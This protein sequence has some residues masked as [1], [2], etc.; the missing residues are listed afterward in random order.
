MMSFYNQRNYFKTIAVGLGVVLLSSCSAVRSTHT[1]AVRSTHPVNDS[2]QFKKL[3]GQDNFVTVDLPHTFNAYDADDGGGYYVGPTQYTKTF[4]SPCSEDQLLYI[5]F[6][7]SALRTDVSVN[8]SKIGRHDGGY[9]Q[10]RFHI[11]QDALKQQNQL[12]VD[13][14]NSNFEQIA[15]LAGDFSVFGGIYR[16]V[17]FICA[18]AL[19]FDLDDYGSDGI[20]IKSVIENAEQAKV[21]IK[22][23]VS[24]STF[25]PQDAVLELAIIAPNGQQVSSKKV[26]FQAKS[27]T[28]Q[29]LVA[30]FDIPSPHLWQGVDDPALYS[31]QAKLI[32]NNVTTDVKDIQFGIRKV[33]IDREKGLFLNGQKYSVHGVNLHLSQR[34]GK[35][36]AVSREEELEDFRILDDLGLTGIR[37]VHYPHSQP[38][39]DH[40]DRQGYLTWSEAPIVAMVKNTP[41]FIDN[42]K[43]Q[44]REMIRQNYNHPSVF[45]WGLGN[46]VYEVNADSD[47]VFSA[48]QKTAKEEDPDRFTV[49]A[50][51]C[52]QLNRSIAL[53]ADLTASNIYH[54]W[55]PQQEGNMSAWL[56]DA[57]KQLKDKN[58]ALAISEYGAGGSVLHQEDPPVRPKTDSFWHPEQ[59]QNLVHE[60]S[61]QAISS[62]D[63]LWA[64]FIWV[65]FDFASDGRKEGDREGINDKGL[66]TYDRKTK[67]DAFYW[68]KALWSKEPVVYITSRR[69]NE[70][71]DAKVNV[72]VYSNQDELELS[73]NGKVIARQAAHNKMANWD[74]E[75]KPGKN[76]IEVKAVG[77]AL[78][79]SVAWTLIP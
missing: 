60:Q 78:A 45:V 8:G 54:G 63:Y 77:K 25:V 68:Y 27:S 22:S 51:C 11:P 9:T 44:L 29:T 47:A 40:A 53:H 30:S 41:E 6:E 49:Y 18:N 12:V 36:T 39:H 56:D 14:D 19:H 5:N 79:D 66:I 33:E 57:H 26:D 50:N 34:P 16:P 67:K 17:Q 24:N 10:F 65:A 1:F 70:R 35:G 13:V 20:Y 21:E 73:L 38:I 52:G 76:R 71:K 46:E 32:A 15:P 55:Y 58:R 7:G 4:T 59:Y 31:L 43:N 2:W 74:I 61:W 48:L 3:D 75:L 42:A 69:F 64:S 72:K 28:T 23:R 37:L 62:K